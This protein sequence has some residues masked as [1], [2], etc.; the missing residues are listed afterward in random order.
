MRRV[1]GNLLCCPSPSIGVWHSPSR[2]SGDRMLPITG[3]LQSLP[4]PPQKRTVDAEGTVE[5]L[6]R[7]D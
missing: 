5:P 3:A 6:C 4:G 1:T 2:G 7:P